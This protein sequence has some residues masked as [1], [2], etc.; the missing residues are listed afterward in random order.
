MPEVKRSVRIDAPVDVVFKV[1]ADY[2]SYPEFLPEVEQIRVE[3]SSELKCR[4]HYGVRV[5]KRVEYCVEIDADP[6]TSTRW[7]MISGG[8]PI[9]S[10]SGSW[11]LEADG[12]GTTAHYRLDISF[13]RMVPGKIQTKLAEASLPT[14]LD[15]FKKRAEQKAAAGASA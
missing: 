6:P 3:R 9:K 11:T 1:I 5:I 10:N 2:E 7:R 4:V 14:M 12:D 15:H 8:G 13:G